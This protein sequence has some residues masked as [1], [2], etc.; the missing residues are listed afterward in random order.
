MVVH[1]LRQRVKISTS[2]NKKERGLESDQLKRNRK[3]EETEFRNKLFFS[4]G[5]QVSVT[6]N[7]IVPGEV[8]AR[9]DMS[10]KVR[11]RAVCET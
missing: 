1:I 10:G 9:S 5:G 2:N 7:S 3:F 6:L 4:L 8:T 11:Q